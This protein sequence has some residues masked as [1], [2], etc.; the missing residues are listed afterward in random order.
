[1]MEVW[2][3]GMVERGEVGEGWCRWDGEWELEG[4]WDGR[5]R[6]KGERGGAVERSKAKTSTCINL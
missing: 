6:G 3:R 1:M 2:V 4:E 5:R